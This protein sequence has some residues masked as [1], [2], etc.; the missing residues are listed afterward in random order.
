MFF[1]RFKDS[2]EVHKSL[3][4]DRQL[5]VQ[6]I[7]KVIRAYEAIDKFYRRYPCP[8]KREKDL[9][10]SNRKTITQWKSNLEVARERLAQ[11]EMEYNNKYGESTGGIDGNLAIK[12][13]QE[14]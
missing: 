14:Q 4:S 13:C 8:T 1:I 3:I 11:A 5:N 10:E 2:K 9:A 12:W 7:E 6:C